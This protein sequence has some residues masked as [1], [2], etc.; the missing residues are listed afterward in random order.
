MQRVYERGR[1]YLAIDYT[2]PAQPPLSPQN[3]IWVATII[4]DYL[5][6]KR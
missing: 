1:Y 3:T 4:Q 5:G 6:R 2:Q